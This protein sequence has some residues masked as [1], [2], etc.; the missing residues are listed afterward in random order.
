[1]LYRTIDCE[2]KN[3]YLCYITSLDHVTVLVINKRWLGAA[4]VAETLWSNAIR[5][6][7]FEQFNWKEWCLNIKLFINYKWK[8]VYFRFNLP[9]QPLLSWRPFCSS[10]SAVKSVANYCNFDFICVRVMNRTVWKADVHCYVVGLVKACRTDCGLIY[11][12]T[13][14]N[15]LVHM[16]AHLSCAAMV[17]RHLV[18]V[19]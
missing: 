19:Y 5:W 6:H 14:N 18:A 2:C 10:A 9:L 11:F 16:I 17:R 1:M 15:T 8:A 12:S 3:C 7:A 13:V 4:K